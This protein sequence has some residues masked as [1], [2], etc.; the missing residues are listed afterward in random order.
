MECS[1]RVSSEQVTKKSLGAQ[2]VSCTHFAILGRTSGCGHMLPLWLP[3]PHAAITLFSL[4]GLNAC[5]HA[6]KSSEPLLRV[7]QFGWKVTLAQVCKAT[8]PPAAASAQASMGC[9]QAQG[10]QL[11]SRSQGLCVPAAN[12]WKEHTGTFPGM[13]APAQTAP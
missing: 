2:L 8:S 10:A 9:K 12:R 4:I 1:L 6:H 5:M 3:P 7:Q 11:P 13:N